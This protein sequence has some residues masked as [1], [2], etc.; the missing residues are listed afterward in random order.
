MFELR[1]LPAYADGDTPAILNELAANIYEW[2]AA[3]GFWEVP[4][5]ALQTPEAENYLLRLRKTQKLML[6]VTELAE[7]VEGLRTQ[8]G[9]SAKI[10]GFTNEEEEIADAMI[11]LLDYSG[12][13]GLRIGEALAAK[14]AYN[15]GRPWKHGKTF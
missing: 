7:L 1:E 6:V 3:K 9:P 2:A 13:F 12:A 15:E 14:M 11:R 8:Q 10:L 5:P 4:V